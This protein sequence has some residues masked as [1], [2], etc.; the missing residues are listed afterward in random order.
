ME[1]AIT[2]SF[3]AKRNMD[4]NTRHPTKVSSFMNLLM[5]IRKDYFR[6]NFVTNLQICST[7]KLPS[8]FDLIFLIT[9]FTDNW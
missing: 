3:L 4:I 6:M 7:E 2:T 9:P 1:V 5:D 8:P